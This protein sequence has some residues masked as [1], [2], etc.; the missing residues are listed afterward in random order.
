MLPTFQQGG[1]GLLLGHDT[2][3]AGLPAQQCPG[4]WNGLLNGLRLQ[5]PK[6]GPIDPKTE[7]KTALHAD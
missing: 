7:L 2:G 3:P 4:T 6:L 5:T 1:A